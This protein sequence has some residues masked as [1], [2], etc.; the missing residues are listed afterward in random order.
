[1]NISLN[2]TFSLEVEYFIFKRTFQ[3]Y[4]YVYS[5]HIFSKEGV[6]TYKY[7]FKEGNVIETEL[8]EAIKL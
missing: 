1:M 5:I 4:L 6:M 7:V 2:L 3:F 8:L